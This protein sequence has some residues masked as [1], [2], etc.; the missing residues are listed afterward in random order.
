MPAQIQN[1]VVQQNPVVGNQFQTTD[2][3]LP[4]RPNIGML[5]PPNKNTR[6]PLIRDAAKKETVNNV[7]K[8]LFQKQDKSFKV[9]N[10][11]KTPIG[12]KIIFGSILAGISFFGIKKLITKLIRH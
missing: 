11:P 1:N 2:K 8:D 7:N 3:K 6:P 12:I 9:D 4:N 10:S 5:Q